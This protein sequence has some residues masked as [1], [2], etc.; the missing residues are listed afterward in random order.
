MR[1]DIAEVIQAR[2]REV[3]AL[4]AQIH[5]LTLKRASILDDLAEARRAMAPPARVP[6]TSTSAPAASVVSTPTS[7]TARAK[8]APSASAMHRAQR[9]ARIEA[10]S[11]ALVDH[12]NAKMHTL[13]EATGIQAWILKDILNDMRASGHVLAVG[14]R[15][16]MRYNL[17]AP[18]CFV[19]PSTPTARDGDQ[20]ETRWNGA[21]RR[22]VLHGDSLDDPDPIPALAVR[23]RGPQ[24]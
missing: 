15:A 5:A 8:P 16:G 6:A 2:V 22:S 4:D 20:L 19:A 11:R 9:D 14:V 13:V 21:Q 1:I 3:E 24:P 12:P 7:P 18:P 17:V 10:V 23:Q